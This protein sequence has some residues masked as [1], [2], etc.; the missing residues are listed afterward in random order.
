[1]EKESTTTASCEVPVRDE[2]LG[3]SV[4]RRKGHCVVLER[5]TRGI[6]CL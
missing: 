2:D 6:T 3:V 4:L 5:A 1:M